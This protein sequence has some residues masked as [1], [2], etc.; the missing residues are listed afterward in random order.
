MKNTVG[1]IVT[2]NPDLKS[3][4]NNI[5]KIITA[6]DYLIIWQNSPE[7]LSYLKKISDKILLWG[8][9][10]NKYIAQPLNKALDWCYKHNFDYLLTMDQDSTWEDCDGFINDAL[11][12]Q[13]DNIGIIAPSINTKECYHSIFR[14]IE[15]TITSGSLVNVNI[16]K[17]IG[18]FN[19]RYQI[20][21]VDG[22][23]CFKLRNNNYKIIQLPHFRLEHKLGTPTK[24]IL[25]FE[26]SNY[27]PVVYFFII[28]NMLWENRQYGPRAV[29]YKCI[30]YTLVR[31]ISGI[32]IGEKN[33]IKKLR[34]VIKGL[35]HG[36]FLPYK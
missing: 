9:G 24:T 1:I 26:T 11:A 28:R 18:G 31:N 10:S 30:I 34:K 14:E 29:S 6:V 19:E 35:Y 33:K 25:G 36:L 32:I 4:E 15:Y 5:K 2:Y 8:D 20:Y 13:I 12:L 17:K 21:W 7:D 23:F 16:A 22:E 27:S 3:L